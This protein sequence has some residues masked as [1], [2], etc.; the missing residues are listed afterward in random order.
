[1]FSLR[2]LAV[3]FAG[4]LV[5]VAA[6]SAVPGVPHARADTTT[7][8]TGTL[9]TGWDPNQPGLTPAAVSSPGKDGAATVESGALRVVLSNGTEAPARVIG[10]DPRLDVALLQGEAELGLQ[11]SQRGHRLRAEVAVGLRVD[12][13]HAQLGRSPVAY[14]SRPRY[15]G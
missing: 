3:S 12:R 1:M 14:A 5:A 13:D 4:A 8:S 6:T 7:I 2:R 15:C 10:R 9:R 11:R